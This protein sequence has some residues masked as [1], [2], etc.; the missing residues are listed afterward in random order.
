MV[1]ARPHMGSG[2]LECWKVVSVIPLP[3]LATPCTSPLSPQDTPL[4]RFFIKRHEEIKAGPYF[5]SHLSDFMRLALMY[6]HGGLYF[7]AGGSSCVLARAVC[8]KDGGVLGDM[9]HA[10]GPDAQARRAVL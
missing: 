9:G 7:D 8:I 2:G 5:F 4:Y 1:G 10:P 3:R 6:K